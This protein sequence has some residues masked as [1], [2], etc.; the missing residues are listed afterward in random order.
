MT[1]DEV[2]LIYDYLHEYYEY[3]DDGN[4][5]K[6][7]RDKRTKNPRTLGSFVITD[8]KPKITCS[9][10]INGKTYCKPLTHLIFL[11]FNNLFP[12]VII[13]KDGNPVNTK[14]DNIKSVTNAQAK[15]NNPNKGYKKVKGANNK[16]F[17]KALF[18]RLGKNYSLGYYLDKDKAKTISY[19]AKNLVLEGMEN[20]EEIKDVIKTIHP[21]ATCRLKKDRVSLPGTFR[22]GNKFRS[23]IKIESKKKSLG[24]FNT[25]EEAHEAYI[26]AKRELENT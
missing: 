10:N 23:V 11:F 26:K 24:T 15:Q 1:E 25:Q 5:I 16:I 22:R 6:K 3:R 7:S 17:Y 13:F 12:E 14:I 21:W 2:N 4:L 20:I 8:K 19:C 18:C 9:L